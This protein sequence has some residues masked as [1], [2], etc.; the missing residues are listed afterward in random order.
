MAPASMPRPQGRGIRR[1][2]SRRR[3]YS[4]S[5]ARAT[6]API[7]TAT[8]LIDSSAVK[9]SSDPST[10]APVNAQIGVERRATLRS[11]P[12]G[13]GR[14][15]RASSAPTQANQTAATASAF[16]TPPPPGSARVTRIDPVSVAARS[17]LRNDTPGPF[18]DAAIASVMRGTAITARGRITAKP[19]A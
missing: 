16:A 8:K 9:I 5:T 3:A 17:A 19:I 12:K 10:S 1:A 2:R 15:A 11:G 13:R 6:T 18:G 4:T 7:A 14:A